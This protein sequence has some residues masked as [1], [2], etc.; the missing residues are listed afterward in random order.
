MTTDAVGGVWRYALDLCCGLAERGLE[1]ILAVLGPAAAP[2]QRAEAEKASISL[3][4]TG[5]PLDWTAPDAPSVHAAQ[6]ALQVLAHDLGCDAVHLHT[7]AFAAAGR[8]DLPC[9]A[10]FHS[11]VAT[12]WRAVRGGE[13]PDD[14]SWRTDLAAAGLARAD[15]VIVPTRAHGAAVEAVYGPQRLDAVHN[16]RMP[17]PDQPRAAARR[18]TLLAV[19]R[20]WD[21]AKG[22]AEL[23]RYAGASGTPVF[24]A[25][26]LRGPNGISA[27]FR[28]LR[29]LGVLDARALLHEYSACGAFVSLARYEPFGLAVLEAAQAGAP[30][31]LSDIASFRELWDGAAL[32]VRPGDDQALDAAVRTAFDDGPAWSGKARA[33]A[34]AYGIDATV[35]GTLAVHAEA[36][37][38]AALRIGHGAAV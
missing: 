22:L 3:V 26:P 25:G 31:I 37:G 20:L 15:R 34:D 5:L 35:E 1:P 18:R 33:R 7:P 17:Q 29:S 10:V 24:A 4:E 12:W 23:D 13:L 32:F 27:G 38:A 16:G 36:A 9:V 30:L 14:F 2:D 21:E 8:W 11:C 28:H 19:G 6:R